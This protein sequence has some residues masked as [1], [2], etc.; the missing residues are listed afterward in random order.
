MAVARPRGTVSIGNNNKNS[1]IFKL[2][3]NDTLG[4]QVLKSQ[5]ITDKVFK[6][7]LLW[8]HSTE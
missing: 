6:D 2:G 4:I 3:K 8:F 1:I 5:K 7:Q